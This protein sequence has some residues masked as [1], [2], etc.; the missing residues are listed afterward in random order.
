MKKKWLCIDDFIFFIVQVKISKAEEDEDSDDESSD[1]D[2]DK[3]PSAKKT[4][5]GASDHF[6]KLMG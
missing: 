3:P 2:E 6:P 5:K 4:K 1:D